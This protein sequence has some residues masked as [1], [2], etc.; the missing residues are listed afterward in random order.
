MHEDDCG[1]MAAAAAV[2]ELYFYQI[3][4]ARLRQWVEANPGRI[5]DRDRVGETPL[6]AAAFEEEGL[7]LIVWLLDEKGRGF[8]RHRGGWK[9][10]SSYTCLP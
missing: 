2:A 10:R 5:N 4:E 1:E 8:E 9:K 7:P 3:N 6:I